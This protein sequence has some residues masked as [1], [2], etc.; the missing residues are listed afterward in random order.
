MDEIWVVY[1]LDTELGSK[2]EDIYSGRLDLGSGLK[3]VR[4]TGLDMEDLYLSEP[5][6]YSEIIQ[7]ID[8]D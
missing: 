8:T 1:N 6:S 3:S 5:G 4:Q 7:F 2:V